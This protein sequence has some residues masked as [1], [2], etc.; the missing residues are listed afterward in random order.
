MIVTLVILYFLFR[1]TLGIMLGAIVGFIIGIIYVV[2]TIAAILFPPLLFLGIGMLG[3]GAIINM[4]L[5]FIAS[6][7][8]IIYGSKG[9]YTVL[10][11]LGVI[12]LILSI[13]TIAPVFVP[14]LSTTALGLI[15]GYIWMSGIKF[16]DLEDVKLIKNNAEIS[17]DAQKAAAEIA[18]RESIVNGTF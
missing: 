10:I 7:L 16:T 8:T 2:A 3:V 1:A 17:L 6:I 4:L 18:R 9:H 13:T 12:E 14:A 15:I 11:W 5:L